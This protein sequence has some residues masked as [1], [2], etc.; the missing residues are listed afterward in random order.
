[1]PRVVLYG[2]HFICNPLHMQPMYSGNEFITA[3]GRTRG[4]S[5]AYISHD[6]IKP[7]TE[8]VFDRGLCLPS[9]NKMMEEEQEVVTDVVKR[10]L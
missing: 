10:A 9:D 6:N 5:D 8:D 4:G 1:M 3:H 2:N 7:V